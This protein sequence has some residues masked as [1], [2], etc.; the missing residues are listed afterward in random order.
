MTYKDIAK[1]IPTIQAV[2]LV[3]HNLK[4]VNKKK[5]STKDILKLGVTNVVGTSLIKLESDFIAGI[6]TFQ[7]LHSY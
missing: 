5:S 1:L 6:W 2:G 4:A 7:G 3:N